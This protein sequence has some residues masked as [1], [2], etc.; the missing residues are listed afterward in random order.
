MKY[1]SCRNEYLL[2]KLDDNKYLFYLVDEGG[3]RKEGQNSIYRGNQCS[4]EGTIP[5]TVDTAH[6]DIANINLGNMFDGETMFRP[7][8]EMRVRNGLAILFGSTKNLN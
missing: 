4:F 8:V 1:F 6:V 2:K 5:E 7:L 3:Y